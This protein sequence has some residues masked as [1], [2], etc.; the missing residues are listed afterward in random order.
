MRPQTLA[1]RAVR[2]RRGLLHGEG[3]GPQPRPGLSARTATKWRCATARWN[4]STGSIARWPSIASACSPSLSCATRGDT[5]TPPYTELLL[6]LRDEN[7]QLI[8]PG[9]V[10]AGGRALQP[11]AGDRSLGDH[12]RLRDARA[13]PGSGRRRRDRATRSR[14]TFPAR[15]SATTNS[16][17]SCA[18]SSRSSRF[19]IRGSASRSRRRRRSRACRRPPISCW[20]CSALGCRFAL[21]DFGVG[22]SSFTYLKH[23]PVDFLKIDGSFVTDMLQNPVNHAMVEAIHRIGHILGKKTIAES[24]ES[25]AILEALRRDRRRLCA[26]LRDRQAG[27]LRRASA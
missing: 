5:Q 13:A 6:R 27:D 4:G 11:D 15:R 16:S 18:R 12:D 22:V 20:R 17:I 26:G 19:R 3:Q 14:S 8:P 2:R 21:D 1:A 25:P 24:V 23:L 7:N 10:P 9:R